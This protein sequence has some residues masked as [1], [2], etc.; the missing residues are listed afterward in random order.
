MSMIADWQVLRQRLRPVRPAEDEGPSYFEL[1]QAAHR[2]LEAAEAQFRE[3]RDPDLV[4]HAIFRLRA[5]ERHYIFL[6]R[7]VREQNASSG[8][9]SGIGS[10]RG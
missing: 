7:Q 4:D 9:G 1:A 5:A 6:L 2:E 3:V 10:T 8:G